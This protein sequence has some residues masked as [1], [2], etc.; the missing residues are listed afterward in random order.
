M[1]KLYDYSVVEYAHT[2]DVVERMYQK[3]FND[4]TITNIF[5]FDKHTDPIEDIIAYMNKHYNANLT[6]DDVQFYVV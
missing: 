3:E 1:N 4:Y 5:K 2:F 6:I